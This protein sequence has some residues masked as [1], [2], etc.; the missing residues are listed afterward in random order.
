MDILNVKSFGAIGNGVADDSIAIQRAADSVPNEGGIVYFPQGLYRVA[1]HARQPSREPNVAAVEL[2]SRTWF[3]GSGAASRIRAEGQGPICV[4]QGAS[5]IRISDLAFEIDLANTAANNFATAV[6][7]LPESEVP[8]LVAPAE[9]SNIAVENCVMEAINVPTGHLTLHAVVAKAVRGLRIVNNRIGQMQI[10]LS[11]GS[12]FDVSQGFDVLGPA[13]ISGNHISRPRNWGITVVHSGHPPDNNYPDGTGDL[14]DIQVENNFIENPRGEGAIA[15]GTDGDRNLT[16]S[17]RRV[18][19][20]GNTISGV[21]INEGSPAELPVMQATG[22]LVRAARI[23]EQVLIQGNLISQTDNGIAS[24]ELIGISVPALT[25]PTTFRSLVVRDN[26]IRE[27][28]LWGIHIQGD[29]ELSGLLVCGNVLENTGGIYLA[30]GLI[31]N[32]I[33]E[34]NISERR[35]GLHL[36]AKHDGSVI[37]PILVRNNLFANS[38]AAGVLLEAVPGGKIEADLIAN[39]CQG[40]QTGIQEVGAED[41]FD[42]RYF[43]NDVRNNALAGLTIINPTALLRDN[44]GA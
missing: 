22:I 28:Q 40:N 10:K 24:F 26:V 37:G 44:R 36:H 18:V 27:S 11:L 13:V 20:R 41:A 43:D 33:I 17:L 15:V 2:K 39:R 31:R 32:G 6:L 9:V 23:S 29:R 38:P 35:G 8:K 19:I 25:R 3:S 5:D 42:T 7:I 21:W 14:L 1:P 4:V 12:S 34:C 16:R 30:R